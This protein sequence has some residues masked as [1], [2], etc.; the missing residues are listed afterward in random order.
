MT[1]FEYF[2]V[3]LSFVL[4]LGVTRLLSSAVFLFR[5][6]DRVRLT[7]MPFAW[8]LSV[9]FWQLQY[10]WSIF[11]LQL[12]DEPWTPFLFGI[13]IVLALLL[14]LAAALILPPNDSELS[15]DLEASF[16]KDGRWALLVLSAYFVGGW[17]VSYV[18]WA[19]PWFSVPGILTLVAVAL[20]IAF[21]VARGSRVKAAV[22]LVY[23]V[24]CVWLGSV[25]SMD[26][27]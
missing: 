2:S 8:A 17:V 21:L 10:W 5:R 24:V 18:Y 1:P 25:V 6:R 26:A 20:P 12:R 9:F 11:E 4:G 19:Q 3:A 13:Y 22:L 27:Y 7:W 14:Y 16:A 23:L 15:E